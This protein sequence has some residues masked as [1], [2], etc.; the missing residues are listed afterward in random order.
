MPGR[1]LPSPRLQIRQKACRRQ[2][3]SLLPLL[4]IVLSLGC[5]ANPNKNADKPGAVVSYSR[6]ASLPPQAL[7][8]TDDEAIARTPVQLTA[9]D[10]TGLRLV[11]MK[12]R[13]VIDAPLAFTELH[14]TFE[15]PSDRQI[16]GRFEIE[17]PPHAA[18]SR[19]AM[20]V[21]GNWQEGEV[22]ERQAA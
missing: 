14:L 8:L 1:T 22:V 17:M 10:G 21:H 16:E 13:A 5:T 11:S 19:F 3:F 7:R 18:I 20:K 12:A 9:S 15:N 4:P 6:P 2:G